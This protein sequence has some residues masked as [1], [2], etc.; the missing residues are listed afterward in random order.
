MAKSYRHRIGRVGRTK[1]PRQAQQRLHHGPHLILA[2]TARAGHRLL[3]LV[4]RVLDHLAPS[5]GRLSH[6][7][8]TSLT[9]SHSRGSIPLEQNPLHHHHVRPQFSHQTPH[10]RLKLG[11]PN[12]PLKP[13][14]GSNNPSRHRPGPNP[15]LHTA[16]PAPRQ[17][18]INPQHEHPYTTLSPSPTLCVDPQGTS[19]KS[20]GWHRAPVVNPERESGCSTSA[21]PGGGTGAR[22]FAAPRQ[23][24]APVTGPAGRDKRQPDSNK[25]RRQLSQSVSR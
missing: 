18:R 17:P 10:L 4:G 9:H 14:I 25:R 5:R 6:D 21:R 7:H 3:D 19:A 2:R 11:Q 24:T 16:I 1:P 13:R 22:F 15:L 8:A 20:G 23:K 12:R